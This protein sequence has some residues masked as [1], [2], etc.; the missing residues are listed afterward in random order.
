MASQ[1]VLLRYMEKVSLRRVGDDRPAGLWI[2]SLPVPLGASDSLSLDGHPTHVKPLGRWPAGRRRGPRRLLLVADGGAEAPETLALGP[3]ACRLSTRLP[4]ASMETFARGTDPEFYWER[5][6]LRIAWNGRHVGLAMGMRVQ[7][8]IHW[9]EFCNLVTVAR[10]DACLEVEMGGAIPHQLTDGRSA[11]HRSRDKD[12]PLLHKHNWL[13]GHIYARLHACGVCEVFARHVNSMFFDDGADLPHAV[14]VVGIRLEQGEDALRELCGPWDGGRD[15]LEA[16]GVRFDMSDASHLAT[17]ERPGRLELADGF[18]VWQPYMGVELYGGHYAKLR[19]GDDYIV[20]AE[21]Q[22]I[23]RG[24]ARTLRFSLSLSDERPPRVAR[25]V[26]PVWWYGVCQEFLPEPLLPVSNEYDAAIES[27]RQCLRGA[28]IKGGFE[29]GEV[30]AHWQP[31]S[32]G[33]TTASAEGD[34][35][36]TMF[37]LAY[38][39]GDARDYDLA[40]RAC[41]CF[42]DLF[43]DHAVKRVRMQDF[44]PPAVALPLQ[45]VHSCIAAWLET[46]DAFCLDTARAVIQ[47]AYFW[48]KNSWPRRA[49]GR[50]ASFIH[51]AMLLYRFLGEQHYAELARDAIGDLAASQWPDGSFGDQG[52]GAGVHGYAAYIVKPWMGWMATMGVLDYLE[53]FPQDEEAFGVVRRFADWMMRE[54]GPRNKGAAVGWTYQHVFK[55]KERPGIPVAED[56]GADSHLFHFDYIARLLPYVSL[57]TG[58]ARYFEAFAESYRGRGPERRSCYGE[59]A[60]TLYFLPWLQAKLW[61][62]RLTEDGVRVRPVFLGPLTPRTGTI[63]TPD[64]PVEY[65]WTEDGKLAPPPQPGARP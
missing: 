24:M 14:P 9:W 13:N 49:V 16:G 48:H 7:G 40:M 59:C 51:G 63:L 62:A 47:T 58:E 55:G 15:T 28:M 4:E 50:D 22:L 25:Y 5:D 6:M 10:S 19:T 53:H 65:S 37:L 31:D 46:G 12:N 64:G 41:Y 38:R 44:T 29:D 26:A 35:P 52:G 34:V 43:V 57:R 17:P 30:P 8:E 45:R 3:A 61:N 21:Q 33:R 54:R 27:A 39:T 36:G 42:A 1:R 23:P 18:L 60:S 11:F 56:R 32:S 2:T 20:R